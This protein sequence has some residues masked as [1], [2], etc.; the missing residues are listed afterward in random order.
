MRNT[1]GFGR[2]TRMFTKMLDAGKE[3][4]PALIGGVALAS[5]SILAQY[6][7]PIFSY[8]VVFLLLYC[9]YLFLF[10]GKR[11]YLNRSMTV[12]IAFALVQQL[13]VYMATGTFLKN[14]NTYL[15]MFVSLF[16]LAFA[17]HIDKR[18]FFQSVFCFGHGV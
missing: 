7:L 3:K 6:D 8:G 1:C 11:P 16:L 4:I 9:M 2:G 18:P 13:L 15:F 5:F 10:K 17:C 12:F 14:M